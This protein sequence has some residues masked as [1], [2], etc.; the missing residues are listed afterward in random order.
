MKIAIV[1]ETYG[2]SLLFG[3]EEFYEFVNLAWEHGH[4]VDFFDLGVVYTEGGNFKS[5]HVAEIVK[6]YDWCVCSFHV[7]PLTQ[8]FFRE[9]KKGNVKIAHFSHDLMTT[10]YD[11]IS[12]DGMVPELIFIQT[13]VQLASFESEACPPA[14]RDYS[15]VV[16]V[17]SLK[18]SIYS[19]NREARIKKKN[20]EFVMW[21]LIWGRG[22]VSSDLTESKIQ[23]Y[24][25]NSKL[26]S[27]V[28]N[29]AP[30]PGRKHIDTRIIRKELESAGY[31]VADKGT[32]YPMVIEDHV[33]EFHGLIG[34][35]ECVAKS[36]FV[37]SIG[38]GV[39]IDAIYGGAIPILMVSSSDPQKPVVK[40]IGKEG[41]VD[42]IEHYEEGG[43]P[44]YNVKKVMPVAYVENTDKIGEPLLEKLTLL[45]KNYENN[46]R[47][48]QNAWCIQ[49]DIPAY[50]TMLQEI[51]NF[52]FKKC[53]RC[54]GGCWEFKE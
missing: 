22:I 36:S 26:V 14:F 38:S 23:H 19:R 24:D 18:L 11:V 16:P 45:S 9:I 20:G 35:I 15:K 47:I 31:I 48:L 50:I 42:I 28:V 2:D 51:E 46:V 3:R 5:K 13:L 41:E 21:E 27:I 39:M 6:N 54:G 52:R 1:L 34:T 10:S 25:R 7:N 49:S 44:N 33:T 17:P 37:I 30:G 53:P 29:W 43:Y 12:A 40:V 8:D 4:S 32:I